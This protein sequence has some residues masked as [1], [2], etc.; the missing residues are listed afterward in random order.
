[1]LSVAIFAPIAA[2]TWRVDLDVWP[3]ALGSA[4]FELA[5]FALLAYAYATSE[6]SLVYPVARGG[7]PVLVL[8]FSLLA[9]S[10]D[11][12]AL[13]AAGVLTVA[14]GVLLVRGL[15]RADS[16]ALIVA[17][18]IAACI[19][20]YTLC[21]SYGTDRASPFAYLE[22]VIGPAAVLYLAWVLLRRGRG[23]LLAEVGV[24]TLLAA[25]ASF[26]A[27][28]LV[29]LALRLAPAASVAAVRE[30]SV[31]IAVAVAA[32]VLRE[33]VTRPRILGA[34]AVVAGV[35]LLASA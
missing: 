33:P 21:D 13:D 15:R 8:A 10:A 29:L 6:L 16:R 24:H 18:A 23:V 27:Y 19:A 9:L 20:G 4:G 1:V 3:Y 11:L 2:A 14:A 12:S 32:L 7:A 25:L 30:S 5:Y 35:V 34:L 22:L 17:L 26:G 28:A 31:V